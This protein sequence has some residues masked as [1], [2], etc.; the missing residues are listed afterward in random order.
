MVDD[1]A[2]RCREVLDALQA[3]SPATLGSAGVANLLRAA[4]DDLGSLVELIDGPQRGFH[5]QPDSEAFRLSFD[6]RVAPA[7]QEPIVQS[8]SAG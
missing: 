7:E 8:L 2:A 4:A 5:R 6:A 3:Q 1:I